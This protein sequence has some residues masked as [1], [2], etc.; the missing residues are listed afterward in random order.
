MV[1]IGMEPEDDYWHASA[2]RSAKHRALRYHEEFASDFVI[3]DRDWAPATSFW[4][5][6]A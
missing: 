3:V 2:D 6:K 4:S 1:H 5:V